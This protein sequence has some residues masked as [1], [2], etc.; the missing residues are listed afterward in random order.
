MWIVL[1][2]TGCT[3]VFEKIQFV[4]KYQYTSQFPA[5]RMMYSSIKA[6][7]TAK[8]C[9]ETPYCTGEAEAMYIPDVVCDLIISNIDG[10]KRPDDLSLE[11]S[12]ICAVVKR[13]QAKHQGEVISLKVTYSVKRLV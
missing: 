10:A 5:L 4:D 12:D 7:L 6:V 1:R 3:G 11:G 8:I 2:H 9:V 13:A